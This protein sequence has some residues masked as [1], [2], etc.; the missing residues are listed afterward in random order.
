MDRLDV[1]FVFVLLRGYEMLISRILFS[2]KS[3]AQ[4]PKFLAKEPPEVDQNHS[5]LR[6]SGYLVTGYM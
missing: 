4:T 5:L 6:G 3:L 1:C 2:H